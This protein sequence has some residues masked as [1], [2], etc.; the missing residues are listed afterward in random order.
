MCVEMVD[1]MKRVA[2]LDEELTVEER[3][4][5]SVAYKNVIG[6]RR[7]SWRILSSLESKEESKGDSHVELTRQY[8]SQ[9]STVLKLMYP[10]VNEMRSVLCGNTPVCS[11]V[12]CFVNSFKPPRRCLV[13]E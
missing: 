1:F 12:T 13:C 3:N 7:A 9:V 10:V 5:I 4:L 8:K 2:A 11:T 6:A